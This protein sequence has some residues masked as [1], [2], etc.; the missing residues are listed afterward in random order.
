MFVL[1]CEL[2]TPKPEHGGKIETDRFFGWKI[3]TLMGKVH[4]Q[5]KVENLMADFVKSQCFKI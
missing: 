4:G 3:N 1:V 5:E 2:Q